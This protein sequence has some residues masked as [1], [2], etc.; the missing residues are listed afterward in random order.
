MVEKH[1]IDRWDKK[2]IRVKKEEDILSELVQ[3]AIIRFKIKRLDEMKKIILKN[4]PRIDE[5]NKKL[6]LIK[7]NKLNDL[8][9]NLYSK[10]GREC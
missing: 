3:E 1:K 10:I 6:E 5:E 9:R 8:Y 2:N 7:F 4:I